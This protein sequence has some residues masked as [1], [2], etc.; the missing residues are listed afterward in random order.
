MKCRCKRK[1]V[2]GD[3]SRAR[4]AESVLG[5]ARCLP[6][7]GVPSP[8]TWEA[9]MTLLLLTVLCLTGVLVL[10]TLSDLSQVLSIRAST[11]SVMV[12]WLIPMGS[13]GRMLGATQLLIRPA[14]L[15]DDAEPI[16][17]DTGSGLPGLQMFAGRWGGGVARVVGV[18]LPGG[19]RG[20]RVCQ[21]CHRG[22]SGCR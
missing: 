17:G 1:E 19:D 14:A 13:V 9:R 7:S 16:I 22:P 15:T 4:T 3:L 5:G 12:D 18:T 21:L 8:A 10:V 20:P 11:G 2:A 6:A